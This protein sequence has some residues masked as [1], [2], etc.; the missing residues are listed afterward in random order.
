MRVVVAVLCGVL[1]ARSAGAEKPRVLIDQPGFGLELV[2]SEPD[3]VTPIG[4][5]FDP[6]GRLL[7]IESHT[8]QR[9][10]D[11]DGPA[12]DRIRMFADGDGDGRLDAWSTFAEG[13][14]QAMKLCVRP[15]GGVYLVTRGDVR[16]LEDT[17]SDGVSDRETM[18]LHLE[19]EGDYPHN[20]MS[21]I[22]FSP[23]RNG[24]SVGTL[25]IGVGENFGI[26]YA[27]VGSDGSRFEMRD[28]A[29][30]VFA[31]MADGSNVVRVAT[32][33]WNPFS[34]C[35][36]GGSLYCVDNDPDAS[37]PC[38]LIK[39]MPA[40]DYGFRFQYGRAG[41]HPLLAWNGELP[42][43]MPMVCGTGEA[44]TAVVYHRGALWVT[45]WGDHRLER[46]DAVA[47]DEQRS[48]FTVVRQ[49][50]V[51]GDDDFRPTGAAVAPDGSLY[52]ADWVSRSYPVHGSGRVWR[53][54]MP[55][56]SPPITSGADDETESLFHR[57][58]GRRHVQQILVSA[59]D[60]HEWEF[61]E[62]PEPGELSRTM[63]KLISRR[64]Q[65][66]KLG[67]DAFRDLLASAD[68]EIRLF[69]V[70]WIADE[71][72]SELRDDVARL[73]YRPMPSERYFLCVL[74]AIEW[75]DGDGTPR[76]RGISD[77]LLVSE[78]ANESRSPQLHA[79]ALRLI[80]PDH[81]WLT[82]ERLRGY[83]AAEL[84]ALKLEAVRTLA[85]QT[86]PE[87]FAMLAEIA[88]D[89]NFDGEL[90]AEAVAGLA[91]AAGEYEE[92][93]S[94]LAGGGD[95]VAAE[96]QRVIALSRE[97]RA[98]GEA[99]RP[100]AGELE[101]WNA[102]LAVGGDAASGRRL[103]FTRPG[104]LCSQ[105]HQ[106]GG[107][108]GRV[109]PDLTRIGEQQSRERII[110]S[111]IKPSQEIAPHYQAWTL[112]TT[113]GL[114]RQ[115]LRLPEGGDDG[116]EPY[117]DPDGKLFELR[118]EEIELRSPSDASIMP[119]GLVDRL[120]VEDLRDLVAFLSATQ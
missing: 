56:T 92:L 46:Y 117:A 75:L 71:R 83:L 34:L 95:V 67:P 39:V 101:A 26:P 29:G 45:S 44:P 36:A 113:D 15:D 93:M 23:S 25:R 63:A 97:R 40:G 77:A 59:G 53:L 61:D 21:G 52:F 22:T 109:G 20:G 41:V 120:N 31:C 51:Q 1:L 2:A 13:F 11:Y 33:F 116:T 100:A 10:E 17:D 49:T 69:A 111:I 85:M 72:I 8:H 64:W 14:Q 114:T 108:G 9:P 86:R 62:T 74:A 98:E 84:A 16:L 81:E 112:V 68:P 91:A 118:S 115:G 60:I 27:L 78:L 76:D 42:G 82:A 6:Q 18:V 70:R 102:L 87:R 99:G 47:L 12:G 54:A 106:Y 4:M 105:C 66:E 73:L 35:W 57:W 37:P 3:I 90:R 32:G 48:K 38:R 79:L 19:T 50:I 110:A 43:T 94:K 119:E 7:V 103:F 30:N 5:A 96:A 55:A 104:P 58:E 65:D 107:R 89:S 28:G 80:S 24:E 88:G